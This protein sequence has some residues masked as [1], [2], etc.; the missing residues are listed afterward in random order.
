[1]APRISLCHHWNSCNSWL[2]RFSSQG[3][4]SFAIMMYSRRM[5]NCTLRLFLTAR[6][7]KNNRF[8]TDDDAPHS[9]ASV[10]ISWARLLKR[11]FDIDI[12]HCGGTLK[13][14]LPSWNPVQSLKFLT[15]SARPPERHHV[16][17]CRSRVFLIPSDSWPIFFSTLHD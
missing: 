7:N 14:S 9:P 15:I 2:C 17:L 13:I 6:K 1:M 12:E 4:I 10:C 11:V 3:S 5:P 16:H 8:D